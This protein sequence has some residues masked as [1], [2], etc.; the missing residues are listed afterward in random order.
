M[1]EAFDT[2]LFGLQW[3]TPLAGRLPAPEDVDDDARGI[4]DATL[5]NWYP[6]AAGQL[7]RPLDV[8]LCQ[9]SGVVWGRRTHTAY[10]ALLLGLT[11]TWWIAG[12][13]IG[14]LDDLGLGEYL[15]GLFLPSLPA[16]L[17]A[18]ELW[19]AHREQ[20]RTKGVVEEDIDGLFAAARADGR[21]PELARCRE[22]QDRIY[23]AR[24]SGP[25]VPKRF[26]QL[27]RDRDETAMQRAAAEIAGALPVGLH[28]SP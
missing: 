14:V 6:A 7:L 22:V 25:Q 17:D 18:G 28:R 4:D 10:A 5:R 15:V 20:A 24:R 3:N 13:T 11:I 26:Y 12:V 9:R 27:R 1:Q 21:V 8:L 19:R 2:R 23:L 16:F